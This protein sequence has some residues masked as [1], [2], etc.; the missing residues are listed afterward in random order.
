MH[1][2][3]A[4]V[5]GGD[6]AAW[7][8]LRGFEVTLQDREMKYIAPALDRAREL[9]KKR[10]KTPDRIEPALARLKADVEGSGI[11]AADLAIEA[12]FEN[13]EAKQELYRKTEPAMKPDALLAT[14]TSSIPLDELRSGRRRIRRVS[15]ASTISIRSR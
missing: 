11:A 2:V 15:S 3:G 5:M 8:A 13:L 1:V 7:C 10:L 9:F 12:I 14:N 4:G 6:I